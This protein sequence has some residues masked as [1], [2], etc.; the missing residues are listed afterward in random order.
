MSKLT[1]SSKQALYLDLTFKYSLHLAPWALFYLLIHWLWSDY[2][3]LSLTDILYGGVSLAGLV[4]VWFI[5]VWAAAVT[6]VQI[7]RTERSSTTESKASQ[8]GTGAWVS[9]HAGVFEELVYRGLTF[10]CMMAVVPF[11]NYITFGIVGWFY[12]ELL[13]PIANWTSLGALEPWLY[14]ESGWVMGAAIIAANVLFRDEHK[15]LGKFGWINAWFM[16]LVMFYL[17][18]NYSMLTA[19]V[20]HVVYDLIIFSMCAL[21]TKRTAPLPARPW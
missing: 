9:L 3:L 10:I 2:E 17:A 6:A 8:L 19:I 13:I 16:G 12:V 15:H 21:N 7:I 5:F 20:A 1:L 11:L 18:L 14:H 4:S